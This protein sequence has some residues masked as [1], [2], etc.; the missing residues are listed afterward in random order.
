MTLPFKCFLATL[1]LLGL[2][3]ND[4]FDDVMQKLKGA[5]ESYNP[6][7]TSQQAFSLY[8][9]IKRKHIIEEYCALY[10]RFQH[11]SSL[12]EDNGQDRFL[13][14][15]QE[16]IKAKMD[17]KTETLEN[18]NYDTSD[19]KDDCYTKR[20]RELY[21]NLINHAEGLK[22][23][24]GGGLTDEEKEKFQNIANFEFQSFVQTES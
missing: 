4:Q 10:Y 24:L 14:R 3:R 16:R 17:Q 2:S 19:L 22:N 5:Y 8:Q 11:M 18:M 12:D 23:S 15:N 6:S 7:I 9:S 13:E 1:L 21:Y 20:L